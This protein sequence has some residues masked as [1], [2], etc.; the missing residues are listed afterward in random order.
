MVRS[1]Y[2]H[3][4]NMERI[5]RE[6]GVPVNSLWS[7]YGNPN[8][9]MRA[10]RPQ[11]LAYY[12]KVFQTS[13]FDA[14]I[15]R[16]D[17]NLQEAF[18]KAVGP[19]K[20]RT[21][22]RGLFESNWTFLAA[23]KYEKDEAGGHYLK[24]KY[25]LMAGWLNMG[26]VLGFSQKACFDLAMS[27]NNL[28]LSSLEVLP[29][30]SREGLK[31]RALKQK[32]SVTQRLY[33]LQFKEHIPLANALEKGELN[34]LLDYFLSAIERWPH[35]HFNRWQ[36]ARDAVTISSA[37]ELL[38]ECSRAYEILLLER[39]EFADLDYEEWTPIA[40]AQDPDLVFFR[41]NIEAIRK[42]ILDRKKSC[43]A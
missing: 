14:F 7:A 25:A 15:E 27:E 12:E 36:W 41:S 4:Q 13:K 40:P 20:D 38:D 3:L 39:P 28:S 5:G 9:K 37:L 35:K 19:S 29:L 42:L 11:L 31:M 1:L 22:I 33:L 2:A 16:H 34:G 24:A 17:R 18:Q 32:L 26:S 10:W 6:S 23:W 30:S 43:A 8:C 21:Q